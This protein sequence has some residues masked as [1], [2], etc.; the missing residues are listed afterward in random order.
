[1][2]EEVSRRYPET[3][4]NGLSFATE[5]ESVVQ[6]HFCKKLIPYLIEKYPD[7]LRGLKR[8][9][10]RNPEL[11]VTNVE[12]MCIADPDIALRVID[13]CLSLN[14]IPQL[15]AKAYLPTAIELASAAAQ[16]DQL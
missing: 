11:F 13:V 12:Q 3:V 1:M 9:W 15:I 6:E 7:T 2:I 5:G 10:V 16:R 4:M 8:L 14:A